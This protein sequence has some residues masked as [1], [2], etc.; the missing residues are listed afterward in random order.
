MLLAARDSWHRNPS[1][2]VD[3]ILDPGRFSF[4]ATHSEP[5]QFYRSHAVAS[6]NTPLPRRC[7]PTMVA[8]PQSRAFVLGAQG[9]LRDAAGRDAGEPRPN[10]RERALGYATGDTAVEGVTEEQR[11][12]CNIFTLTHML[13][14][15]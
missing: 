7:L 10:E 15:H 12:G 2:A 9:R 8:Y 5:E 3:G 4:P 11:H 1:L 13:H 6:M 14:A